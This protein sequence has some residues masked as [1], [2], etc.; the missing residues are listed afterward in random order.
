M[1]RVKPTYSS[2][3]WNGDYRSREQSVLRGR[4]ELLRVDNLQ[5]NPT[6]ANAVLKG[7]GE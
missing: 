6:V 2:K 1:S 7:A 5:I 3:V 4:L